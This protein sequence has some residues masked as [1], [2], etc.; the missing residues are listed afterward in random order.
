VFYEGE[1]ITSTDED[2]GEIEKQV[3]RIWMAL[4]YNL[5]E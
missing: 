1:A 3:D 4:Y 5:K 2:V